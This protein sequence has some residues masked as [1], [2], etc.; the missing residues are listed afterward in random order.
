MG[1][2]EIGVLSLVFGDRGHNAGGVA[3]TVEI[4]LTDSPS[5]SQQP[6]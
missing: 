2:F 4:T 3:A 1:G 5:R 6:Q